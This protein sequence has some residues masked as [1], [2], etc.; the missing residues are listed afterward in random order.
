MFPKHR[1][2][3]DP[4]D[5]MNPK[6]AMALMREVMSMIKEPSEGI[7]VQTP[8]EGHMT[9][10]EARIEGPSDT[11]YADAMFHLYLAFPSEF[12]MSPP[13]GYFTTKI[14]HPNV[15]AEGE[16]CVNTLK[17]DW[18][19]KKW[20]IRHILQVIRCLLIAPF[21]ES[22]LNQ[23]AGKLFMESYEEF[24]REARLITK[25]LEFA[26]WLS[27]KRSRSNSSLQQMLAE[28]GIIRNRNN[29]DLT[30][31]KIKIKWK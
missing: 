21:P 11:P 2:N 28:M 31:F 29:T 8:T 27:E 23:E 20:S 26:Q 15:S 9:T 24:A 30:Q 19:A 16:I 10:I 5:M 17:R 7:T 25:V 22:A 14:F 13:K 12:P 1:E 4:K 6:V 18:D 3:R